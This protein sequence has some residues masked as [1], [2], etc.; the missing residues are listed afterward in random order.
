[1][2]SD[3]KGTNSSTVEEDA[4][5]NTQV[6]IGIYI[7][8]RTPAAFHGI[9]EPHNHRY[10]QVVSGSEHIQQCQNVSLSVLITSNVLPQL[11]LLAP[12]GKELTCHTS[13]NL[14]C[15]ERN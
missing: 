10:I 1:M 9:H 5:L 2:E 14:Q 7:L 15:L 4:A 3:S 13:F 12:L 11:L 8:L 6:F